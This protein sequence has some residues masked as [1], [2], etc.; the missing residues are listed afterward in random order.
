[1]FFAGRHGSRSERDDSSQGET[2]G[3]D[4]NSGGAAWATLTAREWF[5]HSRDLRAA[6][7]NRG[8]ARLTHPT[9]S[10]QTMTVRFFAAKAGTPHT[11]SDF[12]IGRVTV[13]IAG[14]TLSVEPRSVSRSSFRP[15]HPVI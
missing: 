5:E 6:P 2:S 1:M 12:Q 9:A 4:S 11:E 15:R 7:P 10:P 13:E 3:A 14:A 8:F